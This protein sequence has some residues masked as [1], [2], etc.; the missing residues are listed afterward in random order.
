M[1]GEYED[2]LKACITD[3]TSRT[4]EAMIVDSA[5][6]LDITRIRQ[7]FEMTKLRFLLGGDGQVSPAGANLRRQLVAEAERLQLLTDPY[8]VLRP[9]L[10]EIDRM[11][12]EAQHNQEALLQQKQKLRDVMAGEYA[13]SWEQSGEDF[14][15]NMEQTIRLNP[16]LFPV[17]TRYC[18][19]ARGEATM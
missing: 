13:A 12:F 5:D 15:E 19:G 2:A 17:L 9:R 11:M 7:P 6:C 18:L 8:C 1:G 10:D 4:R 3:K 14:L 16:D